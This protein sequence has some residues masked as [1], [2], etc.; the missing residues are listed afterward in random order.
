MQGSA[1]RA[2]G[3]LRAWRHACRYHRREQLQA[4]DMAFAAD[5]RDYVG[6]APLAVWLQALARAFK[7][8]DLI[9]RQWALGTTLADD[10]TYEAK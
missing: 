1:A 8:A 6:V 4:G 7:P 9:D 5:F 2:S 10:P 3:G